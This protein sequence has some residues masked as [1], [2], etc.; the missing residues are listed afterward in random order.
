MTTKNWDIF[1]S[2]ASEDKESFVKPLAEIL[3]SLGVRVWYD[4]FTLSIGDSLSRSIDKGLINS[5]YG[6]VVLSPNFFQ[7]DWPEYELRGLFA[8]E[9]GNNK[10]ILPIWHQIDREQLLNYSAILADKYALSSSKLNID[11]IA[12]KIIEVVRPDI[13]K[14]INRKL[15]FY[16]LLKKGKRSFAPI[17]SIKPGPI[18]HKNLNPLYINSI[19]LIRASLSDVYPKSMEFWLDGFKRDLNPEREIAIWERIATVYIEYSNFQ[20]L[21]TEQKHVAFSVIVQLSMGFTCEE[22][23]TDTKELPLGGFKIINHLMRN[24]IPSVNFDDDSK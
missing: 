7:K 16:D 4:D 10:L 6:I 19:R 5:N 20:E 23:K 9:I 13:F 21:S 22:L 1:I 8:K 15:V 24:D 12:V 11:E 14:S 2:H 17:E 3:K 18:R